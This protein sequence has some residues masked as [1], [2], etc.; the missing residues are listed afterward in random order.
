MYLSIVLAGIATARTNWTHR[1]AYVFIDAHALLG[2]TYAIG[3][4]RRRLPGTRY[5]QPLSSVWSPTERRS[6]ARRFVLV[7]ASLNVSLRIFVCT[8]SAVTL[9]DEDVKVCLVERRCQIK[10]TFR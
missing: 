8:A 9:R 6:L 10:V 4:S 2:S 7:V 1:T 3:C 5:R